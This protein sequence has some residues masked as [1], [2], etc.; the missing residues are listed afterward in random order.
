[1]GAS[2][3][4]FLHFYLY[5][6]LHIS[7]AVTALIALTYYI[8]VQTIDPVYL[9]FCFFATLL[10]YNVHRLFGIRKIPDTLIDPRFEVIK[11]YESHLVF[12]G[13]IGI[14]GTGL[15]YLF[16]R[17]EQQISLLLP[18]IISAG[19][20]LPLFTKKKRIRDFPF[21]KI[22]LIAVIW[23]WVSSWVP[24]LDSNFNNSEKMWLCLDRA[25]FIFAITI[26]F[27]VRDLKV[28]ETTHVKTIP[29]AI[30]V[31]R[32]LQLAYISLLIA[33][34]ICFLLYKQ[35]MY[36]TGMLVGTFISYSFTGWLIHLTNQKRSDYF[37]SGILDGTMIS[38]ALIIIFI[39]WLLS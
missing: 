22:F 3:T 18:I 16:L 5:S 25:L 4:K 14:L 26:P 10:M 7:I 27:D 34:F 32:A 21:V 17:N 29:G 38:H 11:G 28:D 13:I 39:V 6:S 24:L 1:M 8:A 37:Y 19:Y 23:S 35:N 31:S 33:F 9:G 2:L 36:S 30:G 12:Y 15:C 20:A